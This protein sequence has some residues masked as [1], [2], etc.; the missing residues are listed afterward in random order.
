[1]CTVQGY[2]G[3]GQSPSI[4]GTDEALQSP[5]NGLGSKSCSILALL[6]GKVVSILSVSAWEQLRRVKLS[7]M[8]QGVVDTH[9]TSS[10][11]MVLENVKTMLIDTGRR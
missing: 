8:L 9:A 2:A 10:G 1:M 5:N 6:T 7:E 11:N 4:C 3:K